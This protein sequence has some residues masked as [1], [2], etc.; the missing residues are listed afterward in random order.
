[1]WVVITHEVKM[2][3]RVC[4][5]LK[6]VSFHPLITSTSFAN[7]GAE[8]AEGPTQLPVDHLESKVGVDRPQ[9]R[10]F[11]KALQYEDLTWELTEDS[12]GTHEIQFGGSRK[13]LNAG[14]VREHYS[15]R[16]VPEKFLQ[17]WM[18]EK[19]LIDNYRFSH[20]VLPA[21][22]CIP[23]TLRR[24]ARVATYQDKSNRR[25]DPGEPPSASP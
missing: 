9:L 1:V 20:L 25:L 4:C 22:G 3:L 24:G 18:L 6:K 11:H 7:L 8:F 15:I 16:S 13:G 19:I 23:P 17:I 12:C 2:T 14:K 5:P 21:W 10:E